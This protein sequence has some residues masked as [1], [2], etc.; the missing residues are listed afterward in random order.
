ME[1]YSWNVVN[2]L[3]TP[4][5]P[6]SKSMMRL[7]VSLERIGEETSKAWVQKEL[8]GYG[9]G[10][11]VPEYR[12]T[13]TRIVGSFLAGPWQQQYERDIW[14]ARLIG[15]KC[16]EPWVNHRLHEGIENLERLGSESSKSLELPA[17]RQ[18]LNLY[19]QELNSFL[20]SKDHLGPTYAQCTAVRVLISPEGPA[21]VLSFVR[22]RALSL[23]M[24]LERMDRNLLASG[25]QEAQA[26]AKKEGV[27]ERLRNLMSS[28]GLTTAQAVVSTAAS[29]VTQAALPGGS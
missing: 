26:A 14:L 8:E 13:E 2:D 15:E 10:E 3:A 18:I 19:N 28:L 6:L 9:R 25:A 12:R 23:V 27:K 21:R 7:R 29:A 20:G 1:T 5:I 22:Q 4:E 16:A 11:D 17:G 24:E